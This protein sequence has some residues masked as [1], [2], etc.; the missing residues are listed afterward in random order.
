MRGEDVGKLLLCDPFEIPAE[1]SSLGVDGGGVRG[2]DGG[3]L[4]LCDPFEIPA[5]GLSLGVDGGGGGERGGCGE[6]TAV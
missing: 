6:A 1:G 4:L 3:K 2:E 5:E